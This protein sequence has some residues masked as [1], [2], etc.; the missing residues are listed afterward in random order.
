LRRSAYRS[1]RF[2]WERNLRGF[3]GYYAC[4][5]PEIQAWGL[6]GPFE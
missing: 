3:L 2:S 6:L 1:G 5:V 4:R